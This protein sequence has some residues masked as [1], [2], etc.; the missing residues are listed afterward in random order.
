MS[1]T[2]RQRRQIKPARCWSM[3]MAVAVAV[4]AGPAGA[5]NWLPLAQDGLHNPSN[6]ALNQLQNPADALSKLPPDTSG[7]QVDWLKALEQGK[8]HPRTNIYPETKV[9]VLD[10]SQPPDVLMKNTGE[11]AMVRFPHEKHSEFLDCSNCHEGL[12]KSKAGAT[13]GLNMFAIL[14]GEYCGRCHGAVAFPLTECNRC[15]NEPRPVPG[16]AAKAR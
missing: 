7:N 2:S 5:G 13:P 3:A 16:G 6:T 10:K 1:E 9:K 15:H 4:S 11:L 8:I 12:F 14:Q